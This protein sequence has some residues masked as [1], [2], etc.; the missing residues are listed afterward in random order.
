IGYS[1]NVTNDEWTA[2]VTVDGS[3]EDVELNFEPESGTNVEQLDKI[4]VYSDSI[5]KNDSY[6]GDGITVV[7]EEG[8]KVDV[9]VDV[10]DAG[11]DEGN[12]AVAITFEPAI[13]TVGEYIINIPEGYFSL[14]K[15]QTHENEATEIKY[16]IDYTFTA[17]PADTVACLSAITVSANG[18]ITINE[19]KLAEV[20]V[21]MDGGEQVTHAT[22]YE[23]ITENDKTMG[24]TLALADSIVYKG[25]YTYTIPA[26]LFTCDWLENAA[27]PELDTVKVYVDGSE[28]TY[29]NLSVKLITPSE[30][31]TELETISEDY[32][33]TVSLDDSYKTHDDFTLV[34]KVDNITTG[35]EIVS[36][37][38]TRSGDSTDGYT[39]SW[40]ISAAEALASGS[41]YV[42][43]VE[44]LKDDGVVGVFDLFTVA[45]TSSSLSKTTGSISPEAG[46]IALS[47]NVFT[48][49][50]A[51]DSTL[52][53]V[54]ADNSYVKI[55]DNQ[56]EFESIEGE[57][58]YSAVWTLTVA[59]TLMA[60]AAKADGMELVVAAQD[61]KG[62]PVGSGETEALTYSYTVAKPVISYDDSLTVDTISAITLS[63]DYLSLNANYEG[64]GI[65]VLNGNNTVNVAA[66]A[67]K[68]G[69][70]MTVSFSP[71]IT[72]AGDYTIKIPEGYFLVGE[73]QVYE[74]D[75]LQLSR[76]IEYTFTT[77]PSGELSTFKEITVLSNGA[78]AVDTDS[79]P[80]IAVKTDAGGRV[81]NAAS[82]DAI[83]TVNNNVL[84]Y[85]FNLSDT[86]TAG[87]S[88]TYSIPEGLLTLGGTDSKHEAIAGTVTVS[89]TSEDKAV[90]TITPASGA[91]VKS[92]SEFTIVADR[93]IVMS[94]DDLN[95]THVFYYST[96]DTDSNDDESTGDS[97]T[98]TR[99]AVLVEFASPIY[100]DDKTTVIGYTFTLEKEITDAGAYT[101]SIPEGFFLVGDGDGN[102]TSRKLSATFNVDAANE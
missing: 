88:Y 33:I 31:P 71:A 82:C 36:A 39:Y 47:D 62:F 51:A 27:G 74:S 94:S 32:N 65:I 12:S 96:N 2:T 35:V 55:D 72:L 86:I 3:E 14:G 67:A 100:A 53:N 81:T 101:I 22:T 75:S 68:D 18:P 46:E 99:A 83:K 24:Y 42:F 69:T 28:D 23:A 77:S 73:S 38:M 41:S 52:V 102:V 19:G 54:D 7:D 16:L 76:T 57:E 50:F 5:S 25:T 78:I 63:S 89:G 80:N 34:L 29:E 17:S 58:T 91:T 20:V 59:D 98:T 64:D 60:K 79:L 8:N 84:E 90:Y 95:S 37:D 61:Q 93:K 66:K 70:T 9:T 11:G 15:S 1:N 49:T 13:T 44:V 40:T 45:G 4:T 48:L 6:E 21:V 26:G 43:F 30:A 92:I 97:Q 10:A 56:Y 85:R 87:G